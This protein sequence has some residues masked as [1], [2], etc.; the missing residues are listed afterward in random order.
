M[1]KRKRKIRCVFSV[2]LVVSMIFAMSMTTFADNEDSGISPMSTGVA[3]IGSETY[4]T[5]QEAIDAVP[6]STETKIT[7]IGDVNGGELA[8]TS[9]DIEAVITIPTD[10]N[11]VL[12]LA[13]H[14]I[15]ASLKTNSSN[16]AKKHVVLNNGILTIRDSSNGTGKIINTNESSH[17]CTRTVKN[18]AG[19]M[20]KVEG[21]TI[22]SAGAVGLLNLGECSISGDNTRIE[23]TKEGYSGGWDNACAAIENRDNGKLTIEGGSFYSASESALFC[24]SSTAKVLINGGSFAGSESYGAMNGGEI[25]ASVTATGGSFS[26]DPKEAVQSTTHYVVLENGVY[27]VKAREQASECNVTSEAE[28]K[29]V[30][31]SAT[32]VNPVKITISGSITISDDLILPAGST[33]TIE[34]DST[35]TVAETAVLTLNGKLENNG[36]LDVD[37][38]VASTC[39]LTNKG[40]LDGYT[41]A[42]GTY[43]I[44]TPMD[45]EWLSYISYQDQNVFDSIHTIVL[46]KD[47]TMPADSV[48]KPIN[49]TGN[50]EINGNGHAIS[51]L[52][53][54]EGSGFAGLFIYLENSTVRNLIL[55]DCDYTTATGYIGG[56]VGQANNTSFE[57]VTVSGAIVAAGTSYGV[58]GIAG[59][60]YNQYASGS[61][62]FINCTNN[63]DIGGSKAYNIGG[64]FGTSSGSLGHIG[65]YNCGN[66]GKIAAAGSVGY[67]FG[68]GYMDAASVLEIIGYTN[69][70][71]VNGSAGSISSA[72]GNG[73]TI[74]KEYADSQY[75][76]LQKQDGTWEAVTGAAKVDDHTY[77]TLQEAIQNAA[78]GQT[79]ML[80]K[81]VAEDITVTEKQNITLDLNGKTLT[82]VKSH[83]IYNQGTLTITDN[84]HFVGTV[85]NVTHAK[86]AVYNEVDAICTI[87]AGNYTRSKEAGSSAIDAD[88]NET[89]SSNGNSWY[90]ILNHGTMTFGS[91]EQDAD[92]S[93]INVS[94]TGSFSSMIDN[95][96]QSGVQNTEKKP[97]TMTIYGGNFAGGKHTLKND[98]FGVLTVKGG[99]V[100]CEYEAGSAILNWNDTTVA[101][102]T[103]TAISNAINNNHDDP[104]YGGNIGKLTIT[105]GTLK[106]TASNA[107]YNSTNAS[108]KVTGGN[109]IAPDSYFVTFT[110]TAGNVK[111][112]GGTYSSQYISN[113]NSDDYCP[114]Y[115]PA[116]NS[117]NT[118]YSITPLTKA[119]ATA[120]VTDNGVTSYYAALQSAV[121]HAKDGQTVILL[122]DINEGPVI[123]DKGITLDLQ[124]H[125]LNITG[126]TWY[127]L[128]FIGGNSKIINGTIIDKRTENIDTAGWEAIVVQG[129]AVLETKA[130]TVKSYRPRQNDQDPYNYI[131]NASIGGKIIIGSDTVVEDCYYGEEAYD[132]YGTV[133]VKVLGTTDDLVELTIDGGKIRTYGFA[134][135][136]NGAGCD[137]T[138]ITIKG[139][140]VVT[141]EN[142]Q[143][144]YH[145]QAGTLN[146]EGGRITGTSSIEMRAGTLNVTAGV[147][148]GTATPGTVTP[149]G[150][151]STSEGA[152]IAI[153]QHTTKKPIT[154][155]ISG[156]EIL[157]YTA[158][159]ESNPQ[160]N[161]AEAIEKVTIHITNGTFKAINGGTQAL[162]SEDKTDFVSGGAFSSAVLEDYCADGYEPTDKD[163]NGNYTVV[164]IS[165][166]NVTV[167]SNIP[168]TG[169]TYENYTDIQLTADAT[170]ASG[171]ADAITYQWYSMGNGADG[172]DIAIADATAENYTLPGNLSVG[173]HKY[174]CVAACGGYAKA[175]DVYTVSVGKAMPV[176][177]VN[178]VSE[179]TYGDEQ[180]KLNVTTNSNGKVSYESN[181]QSVA[182]IDEDGLVS[183]T[184]AGNAAITIRVAESDNYQEKSVTIDLKVRKKAGQFVIRKLEYNVVYGDAD[185]MIDVT[186]QDGES[187]IT[188]TS[189]DE[190]IAVVDQNGKVSIRGAGRTK[191]SANMPESDNYTAFG[192][193]D[194]TVHVEKAAGSGSVTLKGW[195]YG[196]TAN[197][198]K[199]ISDTNGTSRVTYQYKVQGADDSTYTETVPT[200]AGDYTLKATFAETD[201]YK[202]AAAITDFTITRAPR[203]ENMPGQEETK[204]TAAV[205][206]TDL[207]S[208]ALPEGWAWEDQSLELIPGGTVTAKAVYEDTANYEEYTIVMEISKLPEIVLDA[209]DDVYTIGMDTQAVVKCTGAINEFKNA[210]VDGEIVDAANYTLEEGSTVLTFTKDYMDT[211]E[212]GEHAV[213][214]NY[215]VGY[216]DS[217][218]L[219]KKL[220][221]QTDPDPDDDPS[222]GKP[223]DG[224]P[225]DGKP[226]DGTLD[227][228]KPDD[229][230][231][232]DRPEV[233]PNHGQD[234][235]KPDAG[236][237][238]TGSDISQ[239][240]T[241][242]GQQSGTDKKDDGTANVARTGDRSPVQWCLIVMC[243]AAA[244][245]AGATA[246]RRKKNRA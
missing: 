51:A 179:K 198:P 98:E 88:D 83:T 190:R 84:S 10:K 35:L 161:E 7:L 56:I 195:E 154:V 227:D 87:L 135:S 78:E 167:S 109:F 206:V 128:A 159:Y 221:D 106:S 166:A 182:T 18:V 196:S 92:N 111:I 60:V 183:I 19:A 177:S 222:D 82:N 162:Y 100:T 145:P 147:I 204:I 5:L 188:Y 201:N 8:N 96:W 239:V 14:T 49:E 176:L 116:L 149:N 54:R 113:G 191:I 160:E 99:T 209:T 137:N 174:Y 122:K 158:F 129:T 80:L 67:V 207:S 243:I 70:G 15:S 112:E 9:T 91:G 62:N 27:T 105:G 86:A 181:K 72:E 138:E 224:K 69:A 55:K 6:E 210:E 229:G 121:D 22:S 132:T 133:G 114:G 71:T 150:N 21:G 152:G 148:T 63:A 199:P 228:G 193:V 211:L 220:N 17:G 48:F 164:K 235:V 102:G 245:I 50:L 144:I 219:V 130:L 205:D 231:P 232:N 40:T 238:L 242:Q 241:E 25:G 65:I 217:T 26:S 115:V 136:G 155:N 3:Q 141:S 172:E 218:I 237:H 108:M 165:L 194:I 53:L 186:D 41:V 244:G 125:T 94:N 95:G 140:S 192:P 36:I 168:D 74:K 29:E 151:G 142:A 240:N 37:G 68:F 31:K 139:N 38:Y 30:L 46:L 123:A 226:D 185:F 77:M 47:I 212:V 171:V 44:N 157:G 79:V 146:I 246:V 124:S 59:S 76:A 75:S 45:L 93:R 208:V 24:D 11:I 143:A 89:G 4:V 200:L 43:T 39:N 23:S 61:S 118:T 1:K 57:N 184:G 20:L 28:L 230:K 34:Q 169:L 119:N 127:G 13:G 32:D 58:G 213:R 33:I 170:K 126:N 156:G 42:D 203:P 175:S 64:M 153:A 2:F 234:I 110:R 187:D 214:M 163:M 73:Y 90:T 117:D 107:V 101:G 197:D 12:D 225:D 134:V 223:D 66:T 85:D 180:F 104:E 173:D 215:T 52:T 216:A 120:A 97:A 236:Q 103:L 178:T 81:N 233:N 16:Y 131:M 202:E 189:S